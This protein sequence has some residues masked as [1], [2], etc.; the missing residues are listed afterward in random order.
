MDFRLGVMGLA[1]GPWAPCL[2]H[3]PRRATAPC[4]NPARGLY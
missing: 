1:I 4:R 2:R 3:S